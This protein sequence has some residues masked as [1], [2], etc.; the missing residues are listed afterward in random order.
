MSGKLKNERASSS[1]RKPKSSNLIEIDM[2][3]LDMPK[4]MLPV[5]QRLAAPVC[6]LRPHVEKK[7]RI[8]E[9]V[10]NAKDILS[11]I[12]SKGEV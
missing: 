4:A 11:R 1:E 2:K 12:M 8:R 3:S 9:C 5:P 7:N 10:K 6:S